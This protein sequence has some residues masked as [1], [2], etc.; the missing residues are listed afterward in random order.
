MTQQIN[1]FDTQSISQTSTTNKQPFYSS[2][3][4]LAKDCQSCKRCGL[5]KN[6]TH[7]VI[8]RGN[9]HAKLLVIGE[10]P[11][12]EEDKAGLP[13]VGKSGQLLEKI[14]TSI[15]LNIERDTYITNI[16]RCRP[17]DNRTP[18][19]KE[20]KACKSYLISCRLKCT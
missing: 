12:T 11:G 8:G 15:D 7:V 10:A 13:F 19:A 6:R 16:V 18:N 9:P 2:L 5:S 17:P 1:L 14:L 20:I 3:E 4:Q